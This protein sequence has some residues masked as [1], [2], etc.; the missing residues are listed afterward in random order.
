[1]V[2]MRISTIAAQDPYTSHLQLSNQLGAATCQ[3][4]SKKT[5]FKLRDLNVERDSSYLIR[6]RSNWLSLE[7][8]LP[9]FL[10][11]LETNSRH[12]AD[13]MVIHELGHVT[14]APVRRFVWRH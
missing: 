10:R 5:F 3:A 6:G 12:L 8:V 13:L 11:R 4:G 7:N 9:D 14:L 1:M 2:P